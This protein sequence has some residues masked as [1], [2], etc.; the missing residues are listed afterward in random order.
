MTSV[1]P[2]NSNS[3]KT[4][5]KDMLTRN[6]NGVTELRQ[7]LKFAV[8]GLSNPEIASSRIEQAS[9]ELVHIIHIIQLSKT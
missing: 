9:G 7:S 5:Q 3:N 2:A 8:S 4:K 6:E 1:S